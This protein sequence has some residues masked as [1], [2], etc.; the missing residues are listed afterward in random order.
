MVIGRVFES[1]N[2]E[3]TR[4][5]RSFVLSIYVFRVMFMRTSAPP[6]LRHV[7]LCAGWLAI[8]LIVAIGPLAIQRK[9]KGPYFGPSGYW[10]AFM[11]VAYCFSS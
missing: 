2:R 4:A 10:Y 5:D 8:G 6:V 7:T 9:E 3:L 1:V 11:F